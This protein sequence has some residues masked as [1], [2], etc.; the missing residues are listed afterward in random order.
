MQRIIGLA[1]VLVVLSLS[2]W[3]QAKPATTTRPTGRRKLRLSPQKMHPILSP[4]S[5]RPL[6]R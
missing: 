4:S 6:A 2:A 1:V 3:P 5:T